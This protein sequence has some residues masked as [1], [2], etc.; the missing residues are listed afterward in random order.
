MD[1][2]ERIYLIDCNPAFAIKQEGDTE[3]IRKDVVD[4]MLQVAED[5]AYLAGQE[6]MREKL[7]GKAYERAKNQ[8]KNA[9]ELYRGVLCPW[10]AVQI[11]VG[12]VF[13][14]LIDDEEI[15]DFCTNK[16]WYERKRKEI[17]ED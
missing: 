8:F 16:K 5:H 17:K 13:P 4:N 10:E 11:S 15:K 9:H 14:E 2:P 1:F 7:I 6:A 12:K 3:Y